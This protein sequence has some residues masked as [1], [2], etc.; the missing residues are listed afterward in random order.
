MKT[1]NKWWLC[2]E[3]R[4]LTFYTWI[5]KRPLKS[6]KSSPDSVLLSGRGPTP[7]QPSSHRPPRRLLVTQRDLCGEESFTLASSSTLEL[8]LVRRPN[9]LSI[10]HF[11]SLTSFVISQQITSGTA[12]KYV[13][14]WLVNWNASAFHAVVLGSSGIRLWVIVY[15]Q[16][17]R[18]PRCWE[19]DWVE[20]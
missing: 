17:G 18:Q 19:R 11:Y 16:S 4:L 5:F 12:I 20:E 3:L 7:S 14:T 8:S 1:T 2:L 6:S 13:S 10:I 15:C 9:S